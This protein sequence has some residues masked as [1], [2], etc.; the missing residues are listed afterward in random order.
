MRVPFLTALVICI[1]TIPLLAQDRGETAARQQIEAANEAVGRAIHT[2]DYATLEK[3]W[4][5]NMVVNAPDNTI[6]TRDSVIAAMHRGGLNYTSLK[7]TTEVFHLFGDIA[8]EMGHEDFVM[9]EGPSAGK[10][11]RRRYTDVWQRTDSGWVQ[12]SRQAT[13]L[14]VDATAVY[15]R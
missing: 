14:D 7:G 12:I 11:L 4:S 3:F 1:T 10:P 15:G 9:A 6:R 13:I 2:R 8:V 5:P